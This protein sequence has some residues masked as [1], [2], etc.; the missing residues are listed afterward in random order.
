MIL[1]LQNFQLHGEG[2]RDENVSPNGRRR[3]ADG[4]I[5][6]GKEGHFGMQPKQE[7]ETF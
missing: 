2:G 7:Y 3:Q 4:F 1:I 6:P 5:T